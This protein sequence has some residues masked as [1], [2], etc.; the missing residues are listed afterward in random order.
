MCGVLVGLALM[1]GGLPVTLT[2]PLWGGAITV[3]G[4][5]LVAASGLSISSWGH[6]LGVHA[7]R[8]FG[9]RPPRR[10]RPDD[11]PQRGAQTD[12]PSGTSS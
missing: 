11:D 8:P 1:A 6:R 4:A 9:P 5:I 7:G 12:E 2:S 3:V 10:R